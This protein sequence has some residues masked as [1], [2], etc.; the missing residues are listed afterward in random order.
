VKVSEYWLHAKRDNRIELVDLY[1]LAP[2]VK[3]PQ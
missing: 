2:D 1:E 3:P